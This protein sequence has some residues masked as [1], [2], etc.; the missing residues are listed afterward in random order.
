MTKKF[1]DAVSASAHT[2]GTP[3]PD[4]WNET[5]EDQSMRAITFFAVILVAAGLVL[6]VPKAAAQGADG[7][8]KVQLLDMSAD[9]PHRGAGPGARM[10]GP[11]MMGRGM[12]T[13]G[14]A[15]GTM[16]AATMS[17]AADRASV[18]A[19]KIHFVVTNRSMALEHEMVVVALERAGTHLPYDP[20][21]GRVPEDQVKSMG[22]VEELKP[23]ASGSLDLTLSPGAYLLICNIAGHYAAGMA[24]PLTVTP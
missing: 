13:G 2:G 3:T 22:E 10:G 15:A 19:G 21:T 7:T 12:Q 11:Q 6:P 23:G 14:Q 16:H 5:V 24:T 4:Q 18:K 1:V 20:A 8:V 9:M 17:I